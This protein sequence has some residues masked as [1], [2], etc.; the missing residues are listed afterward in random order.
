MSSVFLMFVSLRKVIRK[1]HVVLAIHISVWKNLTVWLE[2]F[3]FSL[4][5]AISDVLAWNVKSNINSHTAFFFFLS[6]SANDLKYLWVLC[7]GEWGLVFVAVLRFLI[8]VASLLKHVGSGFV[9]RELRCSV[10][11]GIF[12]YQG[13]NLCALHLQADSYPLWRPYK[14]LIE[15]FILKLKTDHV[16]H[17][18]LV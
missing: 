6:N 10:A 2:S 4:L 5:P 18:V 14:V 7:A 13:S 15:L 1:V 11:Y 12:P 8:M 3:W 16:C 17:L 9:V